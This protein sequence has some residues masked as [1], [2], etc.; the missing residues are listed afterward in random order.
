MDN[1]ESLTPCIIENLNGATQEKKWINIC[2]QQKAAVVASFGST[3]LGMLLCT[4]Y[5]AKEPK[6]I[7]HCGGVVYVHCMLL[8]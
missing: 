1:L 6:G 5:G 2:H 7:P 4:R 3:A 8:K